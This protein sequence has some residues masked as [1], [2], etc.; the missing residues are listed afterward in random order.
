MAFNALLWS[1]SKKENS[2]ARPVTS[3]A[4]TVPCVTNDD[5]DLVSPTLIFNFNGGASN[6][7]QYNYCYLGEYK[8]YYW[9]DS[10]SFTGGQWV[11]YCSVDVLSSWK[12][13]IGQQTVYVL[14]SASDYDGSIIDRTYLSKSNVNIDKQVGTSPW[15]T[16]SLN[17][18]C[19]VIGIAGAD[20]EYY[21][22]NK[23][24][25]DYFFGYI[26]S[27]AYAADVVGALS[28]A[29]NES[30]KMIVDPMQYITQIMWIPFGLSSL[31]S[32]S[33]VSQVNSIKVGYVDVDCVAYHVTGSGIVSGL[34][35]F[36]L[37]R[38]PQASIRGVYLN[39]APTSNYTLVYPPFGTVD[40]DPMVC[41]N[42]TAINAEWVM[43]LRTGG[44]K[45]LIRA[46][47]TKVM[48]IIH[49]QIGTHYQVSQV[50]NRGVNRASIIMGAV[51]GI[52][53]VAANPAAAGGALMNTAGQLMDAVAGRIPSVSSVGSP[54]GIESLRGPV[55]MQYEFYQ[56]V[57]EDLADRG[58]PLCQRKRINTLSGFV[59]VQDADIALPATQNEQN[60]IRAYMEGGFFYA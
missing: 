22:M 58:R 7:A 10:W 35:S 18:G 47:D 24:Q 36:T 52:A 27:N 42:S 20:T 28:L 4:V 29:L 54:G 44:G 50:V 51:S 31:A 26:M 37:K 32:G 6:P 12:T 33:S 39:G 46:D 53:S 8:R 30:L 5:F 13:E 55:V 17:D 3:Q 9:I 60:A 38:H 41:A 15:V 23:T 57:D 43:D 49:A 16:S 59:Q 40:L 56:L 19:F 45:L 2:T 21:V 11:A 25:K 1:F 34:S 14:R 48:S